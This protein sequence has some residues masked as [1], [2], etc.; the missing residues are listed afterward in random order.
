VV[1]KR[2]QYGRRQKG[3]NTYNLDAATAQLADAGMPEMLR[4][5]GVGI[6]DEW[7]PVAYCSRAHHGRGYHNLAR[8]P[9]KNPPN[10]RWHRDTRKN[11]LSHGPMSVYS[12][13]EKLAHLV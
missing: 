10:S 5:I 11:V 3:N 13:L 4:D 7:I 6:P 9:D 2:A 12:T 8:V 1:S